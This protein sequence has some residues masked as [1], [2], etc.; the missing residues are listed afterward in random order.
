MNTPFENISTYVHKAA[1]YIDNADALL[2]ILTKPYHVHEASLTITRD[3]GKEASYHAYRIQYNNAR[4]PYKGGIRFHPD[5]NT[6]EVQALAAGMALKTAVIDVPLGGAKGGIQ[7]DVKT[8]SDTEIEKL[9]RAWIRAFSDHIG[10]DKDIPAPDMYTHPKIMG[11]MLDE[12]EKVKGVNEPGMITGKPIPIGGSKGRDTATAQ[13]GVFALSELLK[14]KEVDK[15]NLTVAIQGFGNAGYHAARLLHDEG[16]RIIAIADSSDMIYAQDG[17]D[18]LRAYNA[19]KDKGSLSA[20]GYDRRDPHEII[21]CACD[22]LVP[23]A[24]DGQITQENAD[25]VQSKYILELANAPTTPQADEILYANG[26]VIIPDILANAGGVTVS[27]FEWVQN[28]MQYYWNEEEVHQK[29]EHHM[30]KAFSDV[31]DCSVHHTISLRTAA[32]IIALKRL[33]DSLENRGIL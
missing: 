27:Y 24:L 6:D 12:Y 3:N 28:R 5:A 4:G 7:V 1:Q 14:K 9:S 31:W 17:I 18:P 8:H 25:R 22:I 16:Y 29:L 26:V 30:V 13:G 11:I 33:R 23:A 2:E 20:S 15:K 32:F 21:T 19:K 10:V